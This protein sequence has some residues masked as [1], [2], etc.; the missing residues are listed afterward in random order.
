[1]GHD[2]VLWAVLIACALH[3]MDEHLLDFVGLVRG[4]GLSSFSA[5]DFYVVNAAMIA[6]A[7]ACAAIGWRLPELSLAAPALIS[8]NALLHIG[9]GIVKRR[10]LPGLITSVLF[11]LPV[12]VWVYWSAAGDGVLSFRAVVLSTMTGGVFMATP[13]L[14]AVLKQR[15][16]AKKSSLPRPPK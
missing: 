11:Y 14:L 5:A 10:V 12:A 1:M 8:L 6:G 3:V 7:I 4:T 9:S 2:Y 16:T 13:M 15:L